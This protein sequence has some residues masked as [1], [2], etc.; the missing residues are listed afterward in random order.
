[1]TLAKGNFIPNSKYVIAIFL[2][3]KSQVSEDAHFLLTIIFKSERL[4]ST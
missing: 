3:L 4:D 1:M 2:A